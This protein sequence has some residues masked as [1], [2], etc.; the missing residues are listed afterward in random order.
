V[1]VFLF[2]TMNNL[3][4]IVIPCKN[5]RDNIYECIGFIA[6]QVGSAGLKVIIADTSD[7]GDSLDFLYYV[8][9]DFKYS[10]DIEVIQG[11]F[12]AKARLEGSKLVTTPY[13]LFL[14]A[15]IMLQD[16][17]LLGE[18]L[19]YQTDLVTVPFQTEKGFNWIFRLFD[20]QQQL[21][22]LLGTP[23]AIGGFQLWKTEAY[24]KTGGYDETHLFAEDYWVSQKAEKMVIHD[25]KGVWT[26]ARRFK[27]KGFFYMFI[28][29]IKCYINRNNT[30]FFQKHHNYWT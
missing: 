21:S 25:T 29:S 15:D 17:F 2:I 27:N 26:S 1:G 18:C 7:E 30:S 8:K 5:E 13:I 9:R 19:G 4:T 3:L 6:K 11:G 28:L 24:W 10:L 20:I 16:K 23:F 14:D 12:P 22:N